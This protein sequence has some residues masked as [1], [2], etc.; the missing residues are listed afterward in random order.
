MNHHF[1]LEFLGFSSIHFRWGLVEVVSVEED[2]HLSDVGTFL[3]GR[4]VGKRLEKRMKKVGY[5]ICI[6]FL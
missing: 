5:E 4:K 2:P 1:S 3:M 6:Y